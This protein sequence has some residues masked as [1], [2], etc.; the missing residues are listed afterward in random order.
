[1]NETY[2]EINLD[3]LSHNLKT[4]KNKYND[5]DYYIPVLKG[6]AYGHGEYIVKEIEK[7][8]I[9]Y[10]AVATLEEALNV[11][12]YAKIINILLLEPIDI[13]Y[14]KTIIKNNLTLTVHRLDYFKVLIN[15]L[16]DNLKIHIKI[17]TGLGRL[18]FT[19]KEDLKE[20]VDLINESKYIE[21][22]GI[23]SHFATI[24]IF[25]KKWDKQVENFKNITSLIDVNSIPIRHMGS[26][27]TLLNHPKIDFCNGIRFGTIMYGYNISYKIDNRGLKNKLRLIRNRLNQKKYNISKSIINVNIDL[28]PCMNYYTSLLDIKL[29]NKNNSIGYGAIVYLDKDTYVGIIPI[30]YN[31]GL[32]TSSSGGFVIINQKK[33]RILSIG[34]NMTFI[35]LD[36][37][38][39]VNNRVVILDN[40]N[41]TIGTLSRFFNRTFHEVLLNIGKNNKRV[42]I[43]DNKIEYLEDR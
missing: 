13:K 11:R 10:V 27:I 39:N 42:Y 21:L 7:N 22:E 29:I 34:M 32:G 31:N 20:C 26:S 9:N 25:D 35:E 38:V 6:D 3:N 1:M 2:V 43:K 18:G 41:I 24:G 19:K 17:D 8:E 28:I 16:K 14:L 23:Y 5:Y 30:G 33:Y 37:N 40:N 15:I 36:K 4:I 12:K